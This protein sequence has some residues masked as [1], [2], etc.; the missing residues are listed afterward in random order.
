LDKGEDSLMATAGYS[1]VGKQLRSYIRWYLE[2]HPEESWN[3][4]LQSA[5][6]HE[7]EARVQFDKCSKL[8]QHVKKMRIVRQARLAGEKISE[9]ELNG[10]A[11]L[12]DRLTAYYAGQSRFGRFLRAIGQL[13]WGR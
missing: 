10:Q 4:L 8:P 12:D 1:S 6:Q 5:V 2:R 11:W 13:A 9:R 7:I 3:Q